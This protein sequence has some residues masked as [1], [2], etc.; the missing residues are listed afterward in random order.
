[1]IFLTSLSA[2]RKYEKFKIKK[3]EKKRFWTTRKIAG[4]HHSLSHPKVTN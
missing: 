2:T 1:M 4:W 3:L